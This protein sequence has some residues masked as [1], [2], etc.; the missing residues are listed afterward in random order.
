MTKTELLLTMDKHR[1]CLSA[2]TY[3]LQHLSEDA[4]EIVGSCPR[5]DWL[6]WLMGREFRL[7]RF[8][9]VCAKRAKGRA[10]ADAAADAAYAAY[11]AADAAYAAY[12]ADDA[13]AAYADAAYADAAYAAYDAA[14][15]AYAAERAKQLVGLQRIARDWANGLPEEK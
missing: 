14:C 6:I 3:V 13:A 2:A 10:A 5:V 4:A 11:A 7:A 8:V 1:A 9:R 15:A 12:A